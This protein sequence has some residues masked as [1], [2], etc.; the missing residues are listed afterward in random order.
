MTVVIQIS[1]LDIVWML[2]HP[3]EL[4][5]FQSEWIEEFKKLFNESLKEEE[6]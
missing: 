1:L 5:E 4:N 3:K 6:E 2:D